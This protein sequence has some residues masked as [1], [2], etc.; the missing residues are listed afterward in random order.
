MNETFGNKKVKSANQLIVEH[1][2]LEAKVKRLEEIE[3][4]AQILIAAKFCRNRNGNLG[5]LDFSGLIK[6]LKKGGE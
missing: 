1:G 6:A 2:V 4:A 5:T 3:S